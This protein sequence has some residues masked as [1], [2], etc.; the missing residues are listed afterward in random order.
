MAWKIFTSPHHVHGPPPQS[1]H[2]LDITLQG[3]FFHSDADLQRLHFWFT[4]YIKLNNTFHL[5]IIL[6]FQLLKLLCDLKGLLCSGVGNRSGKLDA[7]I[8]LQSRFLGRT[9]FGTSERHAWIPTL[10]NSLHVQPLPRFEH[11]QFMNKRKWWS[12]SKSIEI[13]N[14]M[15]WR[16]TQVLSNFMKVIISRG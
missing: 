15:L 11:N 16:S 2:H 7:P 1:S 12:K 14:R 6:L 10:V 13:E 9:R 8:R 3:I 4:D 5:S